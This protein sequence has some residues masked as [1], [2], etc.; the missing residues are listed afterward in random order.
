MNNVPEIV[1]EIMREELAKEK[2]LPAPKTCPC[3]I[4][5]LMK[6]YIRWVEEFDNI[7]YLAPDRLNISDEVE[8]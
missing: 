2:G 6:N 5:S 7:Q 4:R 1:A 8:I 3:N